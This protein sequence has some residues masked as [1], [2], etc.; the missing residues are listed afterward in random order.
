MSK[1]TKPKDPNSWVSLTSWPNP[2]TVMVLYS[3]LP[4]A[5]IMAARYSGPSVSHSLALSHS[6]IL[7]SFGSLSSGLTNFVFI[8]TNCN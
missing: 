6:S 4:A 2:P 1:S 3:S 7:L 8:F 5:P